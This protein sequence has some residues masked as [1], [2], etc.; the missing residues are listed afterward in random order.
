MSDVAAP[1][2]ELMTI[3]DFLAFLDRRS[4][5][6]RWESIDGVPFM[7]TGGALAHARIGGNID[8]L[9]APAAEKRGCMAPRLSRRG[10]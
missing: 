7:M 4:S 3:E 9:L 8:R 10:E 1:K 5:D 2:T 6:E